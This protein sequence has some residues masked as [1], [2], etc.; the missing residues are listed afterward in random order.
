MDATVKDARLEAWVGHHPG[1]EYL[2]TG[3]G[4]HLVK[5]PRGGVAAWDADPGEALENA[6]AWA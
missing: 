2:V 5:D 1:W 4:R 3:D 6:R